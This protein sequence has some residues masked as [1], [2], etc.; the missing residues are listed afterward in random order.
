MH[1]SQLKVCPSTLGQIRS[2]SSTQTVF[3]KNRNQKFLTPKKKSNRNDLSEYFT[4]T[5]RL[6]VFS[7]K[8]ER[9]IQFQSH[10]QAEKAKFDLS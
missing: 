9:I 8:L 3:K 10:S 1:Y 6:S 5:E 7:H 4:G 2:L